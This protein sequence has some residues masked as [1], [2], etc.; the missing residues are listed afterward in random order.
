MILQKVTNGDFWV[1]VETSN[2]LTILSGTGISAMPDKMQNIYL[3]FERVAAD[4]GSEEQIPN[5]RS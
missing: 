5:T 1:K 2:F 4:A 3:V